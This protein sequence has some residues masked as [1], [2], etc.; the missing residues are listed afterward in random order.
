MDTTTFGT[1]YIRGATKNLHRCVSCNPPW[2]IK[3][4]RGA[5]SIEAETLTLATPLKRSR[6]YLAMALGGLYI[7][8]CQTTKPL[9]S[10]SSMTC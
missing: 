9:V 2:E 8:I 10:L 3:V 6:V 5:H 7:M 1:D 4:N